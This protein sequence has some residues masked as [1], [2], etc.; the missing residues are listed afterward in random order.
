MN[1]Q[2]VASIKAQALREAAEHFESL[3]MNR[4]KDGI[5]SGTWEWFEMFPIAHL[6]ERAE[7]IEEAWG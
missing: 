7:L 1:E 3:P 5:C 4:E 6:R 2:E